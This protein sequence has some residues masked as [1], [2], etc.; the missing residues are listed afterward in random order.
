MWGRSPWRSR[1]AALAGP[2]A[3]LPLA[4]AAASETRGRCYYTQRELLCGD[5]TTA[6]QR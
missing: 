1:A 6:C 3:R 5:S 2:A 4:C